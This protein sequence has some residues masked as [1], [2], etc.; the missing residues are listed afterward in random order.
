MISSLSTLISP[1]IT[2]LHSLARHSLNLLL[3][4]PCLLCG[5]KHSHTPELICQCCFDAL[6]TLESHLYRC[7]CCALPLTS[8]ANLCGQC[9]TYPPAFT[10]AY[11]PFLYGHP[12]DSLIHQF[13]YRRQLASGKLLGELLLETVQRETVRPDLI[14]PTPIHWQ[15]RW[16]RGFNQT[17]VL[18]H[19]LG[20]SL[21]IPVIYACLQPVG[22]H[23][24]KE[25][26]RIERFK[27]LRRRFVI[28]PNAK[29][30]IRNAHI[31]LLDDVVTTTATARALSELLVSAGAKRVDIW[32][33]ARTPEQ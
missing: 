18:A 6:P 13:K 2:P 14:V 19:Q 15:R 23:S 10:R 5:S 31:A 16:S 3:P 8:S 30:Q 28:D 24:Q 1:V 7:S 17:E 32:A 21:S 29:V 9:L 22:A 12:L 26:S 33:L 25:L 27:N 20:K 11:I 4:T